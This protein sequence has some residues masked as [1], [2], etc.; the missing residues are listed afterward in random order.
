MLL[1]TLVNRVTVFAAPNPLARR[2]F[3]VCKFTQLVTED[4]TLHPDKHGYPLFLM[5]AVLWAIIVLDT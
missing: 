5:N 2:F 1:R 3:F 4:V